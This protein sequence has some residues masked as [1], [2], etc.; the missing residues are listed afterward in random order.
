MKLQRY[1]LVSSPAILNNRYYPCA[2]PLAALEKDSRGKQKSRP[3]EKMRHPH[4]NIP[5]AGQYKNKPGPGGNSPD[6]AFD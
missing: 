6:P 3:E 5:R 4:E 2:I 1:A